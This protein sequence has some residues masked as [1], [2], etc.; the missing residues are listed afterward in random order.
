MEERGA[1]SEDRWRTNL[2]LGA[3][4]IEK[5]T[6]KQEKQGSPNCTAKWKR[7][8]EKIWVRTKQK[9]TVVSYGSKKTLVKKDAHKVGISQ[10]SQ[11]GS[12][13]REGSTKTL[14]LPRCL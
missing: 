7:E 11:R 8:G 3:E 5:T 6:I 13:A 4:R 2:S 9:T 10:H 1:C 14:E 12:N